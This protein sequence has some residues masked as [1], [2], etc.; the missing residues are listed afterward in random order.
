MR[1]YLCVLA[2]LCMSTAVYAGGMG[3]SSGKPR[4]PVQVSISPVKSGISPADIKPGDIVEF[5]IS[6]KTYTDAGELKIN[7][8]LLGGV[9]LLSGNTTWAGPALK[10]EDKLLLLSVI[11]PKHGN[12]MIRARILMSPSSEA[13]FS[14]EAEYRFGTYAEKK[15]ALLPEIKKD[16]KGRS[17]REHRVN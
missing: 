12:G 5:K 8:E 17:I 11:V 6:G 9:E 1:Y 10:G 16:S 2:I 14:A 15:P 7:V 4:S 3:A 13:S